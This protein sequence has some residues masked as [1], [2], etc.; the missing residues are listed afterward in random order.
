M[1]T[2]TYIYIYIYTCVC[3]FYKGAFQLYLLYE[4]TYLYRTYII[5]EDFQEFDKGINYKYSCRFLTDICGDLY[6][7]VQLLMGYCI[8]HTF[9]LIFITMNFRSIVLLIYFQG[10]FLTFTCSKLLKS[11]PMNVFVSPRH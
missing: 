11:I 4:K 5:I 9:L 7:Y 3:L 2:H 8:V 10:T 1:Y 6:L